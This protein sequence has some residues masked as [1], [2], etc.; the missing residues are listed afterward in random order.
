MLYPQTFIDDLKRQ[1]DIVR[2]IQD[3]EKE[4]RK[5][6]GVLPFPQGENAIILRQSIERDLLLL[7]LS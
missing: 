7:W 1:A 4:G 3:Y 5:L 2:V 6:D